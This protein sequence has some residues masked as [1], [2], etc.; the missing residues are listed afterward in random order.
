VETEVAAGR[1]C[2]EGERRGVEE[3]EGW[4][5]CDEGGGEDS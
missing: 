1:R 3:L 2:Y 4:D 5:G